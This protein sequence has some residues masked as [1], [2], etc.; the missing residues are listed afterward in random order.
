[1]NANDIAKEMDRSMRW[2]FRYAFHTGF[3]TPDRPLFRESVGTLDLDVHI[4][5]AAE[6]GF[7]GVQDLWAATRPVEEQRALGKTLEQY[8]LEGGSVFWTAREKVRAPLWAASG[9][10]ARAAIAP[11]LT[12][13]IDSARRLHSRNVII[14]SGARPDVPASAK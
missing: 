5:F 11:D 14:F 2:N 6:L 13:A 10:A 12:A 8:G 4:R 3:R 7:A 1:L 9:P